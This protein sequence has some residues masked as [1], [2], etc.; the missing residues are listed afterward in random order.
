M[1]IMPVVTGP[2]HSAN[3]PDATPHQ[4]YHWLAGDRTP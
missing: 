4:S 1:T 2:A 3:N